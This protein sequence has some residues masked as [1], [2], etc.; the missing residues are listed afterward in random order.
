MFEYYKIAKLEVGDVSR[1]NALEEKLGK[2]IMAFESGVRLARLTEDE[3]EQ[4]AALEK[5]LG[6]LFLVFDAIKK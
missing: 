1:I 5:E 2:H 3:V 4:V 6:V